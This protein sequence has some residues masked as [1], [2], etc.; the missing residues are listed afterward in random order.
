LLME[1]KEISN[2]SGRAISKVSANILNVVKSPSRRLIVTVI[3][4]DIVKIPV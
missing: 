3:N 1:P 4:N 2:P